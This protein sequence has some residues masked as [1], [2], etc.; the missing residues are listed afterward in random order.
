M[1]LQCSICLSYKHLDVRTEVG[2]AFPNAG[3]VGATFRI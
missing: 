1:L 3:P 2:V